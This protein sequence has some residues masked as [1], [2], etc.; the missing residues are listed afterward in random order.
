V[1]LFLRDIEHGTRKRPTWSL[2]EN[3][4]HATYADPGVKRLS[5]V[6]VRPAEGTDNGLHLVWRH[7]RNKLTQGGRAE[8]GPLVV[9]HG[10]HR[11]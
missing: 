8:I 6:Q 3:P 2:E 1:P 7:P 11:G 4:Q 9:C 5:L 10:I